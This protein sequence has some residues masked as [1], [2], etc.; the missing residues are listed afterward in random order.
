MK[1][2]ILFYCN[3]TVLA[4]RFP[5]SNHPKFNNG[6]K[7]TILNLIGLIFFTAYPTDEPTDDRTDDDM[8]TMTII[9]IRQMLT[10][11]WKGIL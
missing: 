2:Q 6:R 7:P 5:D 1:S 10:E 9:G 3:S 11:T 8:T 4:I